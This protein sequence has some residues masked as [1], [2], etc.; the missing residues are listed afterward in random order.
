MILITDYLLVIPS[1][2]KV[3]NNEKI[4]EVIELHYD[5]IPTSL[6]I[7]ILKLTA[8]HIFRP[9]VNNRGIFNVNIKYFIYFI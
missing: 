9:K 1:I 8:Q 6:L 5:S 2:L 4:N 7:E 3:N